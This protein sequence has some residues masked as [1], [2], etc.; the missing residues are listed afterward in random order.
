MAKIRQDLKKI[1]TAAISAVNPESAIRSHCK[2]DGDQLVLL[3]DNRKVKEYDL[4][5]FKRVI[6]IGSGKATAPM[7]KAIEELL[8]DRIEQG[9][10]SVKYGYTVDLKKIKIIEAS[11]PIPDTC[12]T[13]PCVVIISR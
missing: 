5:K 4:K 9:C 3:S 12:S 1:Y 2:R 8:A 6:V 10:I 11:H 7:A 13:Q